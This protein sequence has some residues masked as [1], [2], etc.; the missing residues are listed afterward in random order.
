MNADGR[1][2]AVVDDDPAV[3]DSTRFLLEV[4]DLGVRTY[5][6]GADFFRDDPDIA[7]LIVDYQMPDLNGLE[8]VSELRKRGSNVPAIMIT[9][10]ANPAV[11]RRAAELGIRRVLRK[12][13]SNN[14]LLDAICQE[15]A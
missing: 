2:V 7:C 8:I 3:C 5:T 6:S 12:P 4:H 14:E 11:D 13:L 10:T 1:A 9:A 15:L